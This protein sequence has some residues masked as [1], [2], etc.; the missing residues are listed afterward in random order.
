MPISEAGMR[1]PWI[2]VGLGLVALLLASWYEFGRVSVRGEWRVTH[3]GDSLSVTH[4]T[5]TGDSTVM[6]KHPA[7]LFLFDTDC[8]YCRPARARIVKYLRTHHSRIVH[9]YGITRDLQFVKNQPTDGPLPYYSTA[10]PNSGLTFVTEVPAF[11]RTGVQGHVLREYV[12]IPSADVL[13]S[14]FE[15]GPSRDVLLRQ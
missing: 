3:V 2:M 13:D 14:L 11:V 8:R 1:W 10:G 15:L 5:S 7:L 4:L 12:G 6:V 9:L